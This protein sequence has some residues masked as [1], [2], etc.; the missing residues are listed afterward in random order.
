MILVGCSGGF[1]RAPTLEEIIAD[2]SK[3]DGKTVTVEGWLFKCQDLDC[4]IFPSKKDLDIMSNV[5]MPEAF[6]KADSV[7]KLH[8]VSIGYNANFD[9]DAKPLQGRHVLLTAKVNAAEWGGCLDRCAALEPRSI[10][11]FTEKAPN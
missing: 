3:F 1:A 4:V 2:P 6:K 11:L 10:S 9:H 7:Y 8:G 5:E